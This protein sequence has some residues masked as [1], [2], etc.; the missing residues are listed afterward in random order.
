MIALC[1]VGGLLWLLFTMA[2]CKAAKRGDEMM[3]RWL[4]K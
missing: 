1:I 2:I 4:G 3:R